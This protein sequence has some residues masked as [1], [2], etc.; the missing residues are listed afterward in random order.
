M[1]IIKNNNTRL[2]FIIMPVIYK[3]ISNV[4]IK[5]IFI[6]QKYQNNVCAITINCF[7]LSYLGTKSKN[8]LSGCG[9]ETKISA[10]Y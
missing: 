3:E 8:K 9:E 6:M 10:R 5:L 2:L 4:Y 7:N 1:I